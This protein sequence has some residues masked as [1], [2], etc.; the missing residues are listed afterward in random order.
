VTHDHTNAGIKRRTRLAAARERL[1]ERLAAHGRS[2]RVPLAGAV[3]R[4]LASS[5]T[6]D[7]AV[8]SEDRAAVDGWAVRADDTVDAS[9]RAPTTLRVADEVTARRAVPVDTGQPLPAGADAVVRTE[10]VTRAD[11][12]IEVET[13]VP[14]GGDVVARGEDVTAGQRLYETGYRLR[15]SDL[16][17][18]RAVGVD[19]PQVAEPPT[20]AVIPT[21]DELVAADPGPGES[22]ETNGVVIDRLVAQWGGDATVGGVV[23]DEPAAVRERLAQAASADLVVTVGGTAVGSRDHLPAVV[24]DDGA[25][26]VRGLATEPAHPT[27]LGV[28]D[29]TPVVCLPGYPV[30]CVVAAVQLVRPAIRWLAGGDAPPHPTTRARLARKVASGPGVRT[31]AQVRLRPPDAT[32]EADAAASV[33][34]SDDAEPQATPTDGGASAHSAVAL[35]DGWVVVPE[36]REGIDAGETVT[37]EHWEQPPATGGETA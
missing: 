11:E 3:G 28:V 5:V 37:V 10:Q 26:F 4:T 15:P 27:T 18:L 7:R 20:V 6:A 32:D 23:S 1:R 14:V 17:L 12:E 25:V 34:A 21:G 36:S 24:D 31:F 35:A 9:R 8:P 30:A 2:E 19:R 29:D 16:G 33:V 22:V 13:A